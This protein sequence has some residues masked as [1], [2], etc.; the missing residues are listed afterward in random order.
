MIRYC[1]FASLIKQTNFF[2]EALRKYPLLPF[3]DRKCV[4]DYK[5]PNSDLVIPSGTSIYISLNGLQWDPKYFPDPEKFDPF[6]FSD[7]R[8][9]EITPFTYMPFGEGPRNCIG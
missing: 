4:A 6:R 3:L 2:L 1:H 7:E 8:K 9:E 5:V